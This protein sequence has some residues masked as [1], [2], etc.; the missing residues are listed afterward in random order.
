MINRIIHD[1][2]DCPGRG[3]GL[4]GVAGKNDVDPCRK[5]RKIPS[6]LP[7][8]RSMGMVEMDFY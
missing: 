3:M 1:Q 6:K 4:K 2:H 8:S 5:F 7:E